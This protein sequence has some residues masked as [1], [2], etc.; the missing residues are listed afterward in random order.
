M[1]RRE[2][3]MGHLGRRAT[4]ALGGLLMVAALVVTPLGGPLQTVGLGTGRAGA[5]ITATDSAYA[6][7]DASGGVMTFGGAGY[8]GDAIE[9]PLQKPI[10]GSAA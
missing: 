3:G 8:D 1:P 5:A 7:V 9:V 2:T 6:I 4:V 10:V